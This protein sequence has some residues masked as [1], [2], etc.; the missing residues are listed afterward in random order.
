MNV[1]Q[2]EGA[3]TTTATILSVSAQQ[4]SATLLQEARSAYEQQLFAKSQSLCQQIVRQELE[5]AEAWC[6]LGKTQ[7]KLRLYDE[8]LAALYRLVRLQENGTS[9]LE[10][11]LGL[12]QSH[13]IDEAIVTASN[14][15]N[16]IKPVAASMVAN[17]FATALF[18]ERLELD[19]A[20]RFYRK[21]ISLNPENALGYLNLGLL[22]K[23]IGRDLEA[24]SSFAKAAS[25]SSTRAAAY[26]ALGMLAEK[27]HCYSQAAEHFRQAGNKGAIARALRKAASWPAL[28]QVDADVL[29]AIELGEDFEP[30]SL[31]CMPN[32]TPRMHKR[33]ATQHAKTLFG[34]QLE[35]ATPTFTFGVDAQRLKIGYLSA[36]FYSHAT[37]YLLAG[38]LEQH[39]LNK[40]DIH[41]YSYSSPTAD[42]MTSRLG[43]LG[44]PLHDCCALSD[45]DLAAKIRHDQIQI[46]V[47]LKGYTK[48]S[49]LGVNRL[50]PA[51]IIVNWLGYP[52]TLGHCRLADYMIGDP[53]VTPPEFAANYT[54]TLALMPHC[55]QPN[56]QTR[57]ISQRSREERVEPTSAGPIVVC[58]NQVMKIN[59]AQFDIWCRILLNIPGSTLWL[60]DPGCAETK[61]NLIGEA[62]RRGI[63]AHRL[64]FAA[65]LSNEEHLARL[66]M[67]DLA[68]DTFPYNSHTTASDALWAGVPLI[69]KKGDTFA[70]RVAASLLTA[71][72]FPELVTDRDE[73]YAELAL[74]LLRSPEKLKNLRQ[75]FSSA[76][77]TSPI[78]DTK[79]FTRNLE[80]LFAEMWARYLDQNHSQIPLIGIDQHASQIIL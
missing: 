62:A 51:P 12:L 22:L 15:L 67:A 52:G 5:N 47:D 63:S 6:L 11:A 55:Y 8:G 68:V 41:L 27:K 34:E 48:G 29:K 71:H 45:S 64:L 23:G 13:R 32:L 70:S 77:A 20:E 75:R 1:P 44:I 59:P 3:V 76:N 46:L 19:T 43:R 80:A 10:L 2:H 16:A 28:D 79:R 17:N 9:Y 58:F 35:E 37:M 73:A 57:K 40:V 21:A 18:A 56:D 61:K 30:L 49:R 72:G 38:V 69:T 33:A 50:R 54:E 25:F 66:Q 24:E 42:I 39:D 53:V 65:H 14:C 7:I 31:A 36:D 26:H 74:S 4:K 78:F 60:L